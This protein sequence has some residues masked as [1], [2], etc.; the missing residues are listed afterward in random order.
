MHELGYGREVVVDERLKVDLDQNADYLGD[1]AAGGTV[2][3]ERYVSLHPIV[4]MGIVE[5]RVAKEVIEELARARA[6]QIKSGMQD[7]A[8]LRRLHGRSPHE[9]AA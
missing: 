4:L 8:K 5:C 6:E 1:W 3:H 9:H 7:L 2:K